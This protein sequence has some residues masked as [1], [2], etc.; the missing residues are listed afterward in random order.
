MRK[1]RRFLIGARR[2][3][4]ASVMC[5]P[6]GWSQFNGTETCA[7]CNCAPQLFQAIG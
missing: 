6:S 3:M 2:R 4:T 1:M 7:H 5:A